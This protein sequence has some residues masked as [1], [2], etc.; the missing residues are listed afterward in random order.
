MPL[1]GRRDEALRIFRR[2][3]ELLEPI[4]ADS[5]STTAEHELGLILQNIGE[6]E[7]EQR[8]PE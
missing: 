4:V 2:A 8:S 1:K 5:D 7:R 6:I 3:Q